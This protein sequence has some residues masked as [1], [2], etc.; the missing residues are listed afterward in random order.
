MLF[1]FSRDGAV[2]GAQY[3]AKL[4]RRKVPANGVIVSAVVAAIITLPALV[5]V[6]IGTDEAPIIVP[7]AFFAVVSIGGHRPLH[8][9]RHPDL[10]ALAGRRRLQAGHVEPRQ[11][12]EVDGAG[13]RRRDRDHLG[14]TSSSRSRPAAQPVQRRASSGSSS[15]TPRS[16]PAA[17]CSPCGSAGTCRPRSGSPG[18]RRRST[19]PRASP[20]PTRS[21]WSTT[22]RPRTAARPHDWKPGDP[23]T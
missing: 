23:L 22:A 18:R 14:R 11:Q 5:E 16:S 2:P 10:P 13:R 7:I 12:V 1:A 19:C 21:R 20:R 9:L 3:W 4:N 15:T 8:R 17:R 6:N